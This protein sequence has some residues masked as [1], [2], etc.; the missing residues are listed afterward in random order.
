MITA[1]RIQF[2]E[3]DLAEMKRLGEAKLANANRRGTKHVNR[4]RSDRIAGYVDGFKGEW[5]V[6]DSLGIPRE[7]NIE[8]VADS[9][10]D[11]AFGGRTINVRYTPYRTGRLMCPANKVFK[12]DWAILVIAAPGVG[13]V[14]IVGGTTVDE[15][16]ADAR[17]DD[18][19]WGPTWY[20]EQPELA[21]WAAIKECWLGD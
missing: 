20:M 17:L 14:E 19:G 4:F 10:S 2:T 1:E 15:F 13:E 8:G 12:C 18:F 3:A 7:P 5:A 9:G 16:Y 11:V 21:P 6:A